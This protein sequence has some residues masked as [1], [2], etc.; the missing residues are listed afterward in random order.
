MENLYCVILPEGS[1]AFNGIA[2]DLHEY[3]EERI[4]EVL[5]FTPMLQ[6]SED[7]G[8]LEMYIH[9]DTYELLSDNELAKLD[10]LD[11]TEDDSLEA[12]CRLLNVRIEL[13]KGEQIVTCTICLKEYPEV[14]VNTKDFVEE[15]ICHNCLPKHPFRKDLV[16]LGVNIYGK[17]AGI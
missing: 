5:G 1:I 15:K 8:Y 4:D 14:L 11:I 7:E 6:E 9:T 3:L 2:C 12:I 16:L 13:Y 10:E 17:V